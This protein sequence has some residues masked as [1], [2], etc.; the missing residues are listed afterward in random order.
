M[1]AGSFNF[2]FNAGCEYFLSVKLKN[3][4]LKMDNGCYGECGNAVF[5]LNF[6]LSGEEITFSDITADGV[7]DG[8]L[9][10]GIKYNL[11]LIFI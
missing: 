7:L 1:D 8:F 2:K 10:G 11:K 9:S 5:N 3:Y 6:T 4:V